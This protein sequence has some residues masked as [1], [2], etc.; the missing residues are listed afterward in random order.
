VGEI[1]W[2]QYVNSPKAEDMR[3][4]LVS[5]LREAL[6]RR[7]PEYMVPSAFVIL[8]RLPLSSNGKLDRRALPAPELGEYADRDYEAPQ[9][10]VEKTLARIWQETLR[11]D[12][13]GR[14][15]NFFELGGHSLLSVSL[16]ARVVDHFAIQ[17]SALAVF[18]YPTVLQ[19][20]QVVESLRSEAERPPASSRS[21]FE[22]IV[23]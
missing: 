10:E 17:L 13:V 19:M 2:R 20:A 7:L 22:E 18:Q 5:R 14:H 9:G 11:T 6:G 3:V 21:E 12:R 4:E 1:D 23:I 16:I 15:D 8:D